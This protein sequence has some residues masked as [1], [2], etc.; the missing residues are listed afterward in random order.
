MDQQQQQQQQGVAGLFVRSLLRDTILLKPQHVGSN[1][2]E[3]LQHRLRSQFEGVCSRHGYVLP[4]SVVV[5]R[6]APGQVE[7]ISL[8]GDVRYDVQYYASVCNPAIGTVV[9]A[10]V[11]N[12]NRFGVL[13]QSGVQ[14]ADG[15]FLPV[16]ECI[17][18]RQVLGGMA[19]EVDLDDLVPG[20]EVWVEILGKKF[21][22]NDVKVSIVGR[23]VTA[24]TA[25]AAT[26]AAAAA[27][28]SA[29]QALTA[30]SAAA[31]ASASASAAAAAAAAAVDG[32]MIDVP[33]DS[34]Y[35][36]SDDGD[37]GDRET[38]R[39][40]KEEDDEEHEEGKGVADA[41]ADAADSDEEAA[42]GKKERTRKKKGVSGRP[43]VV[44]DDGASDE[45]DEDDDD[46]DEDEEEEDEDDEE[47]GVA[48]SDGDVVE[49]EDV[50][51][52]EE[53]E[54]EDEDADADADTDAASASASIGVDN[55]EDVFVV[56]GNAKGS[57]SGRTRRS[58]RGKKGA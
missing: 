56:K 24:E 26:A 41:D 4:G 44:G 21:E 32:R 14:H 10:R 53:L 2:R 29:G 34:V 11:V 27:A 46:E 20:R 31:A 30:A 23:A 9:G 43:A 37:P 58:G 28:A 5:H 47:E 8:N 3:V 38:A 42:A 12:S 15:E 54:E 25:A 18:T 7:A 57:S 52:E 48:G 49:D 40:D 17:V 19:S 22:L 51:E 13:A 50:E 1:Y 6:V 16:L 55:D 33:L 36:Y 45:D 35:D 39:A